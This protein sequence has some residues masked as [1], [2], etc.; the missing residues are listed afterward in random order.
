MYDYD[1]FDIRIVNYP[2]SDYVPSS[3]FFD[4]PE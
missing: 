4:N 2:D 3:F 1:D